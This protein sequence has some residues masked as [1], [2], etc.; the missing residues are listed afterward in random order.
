MRHETQKPCD[1]SC[2]RWRLPVPLASSRVLFPNDPYLKFSGISTTL[3]CEPSFADSSQTV[4]A[5]RG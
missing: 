5:P 2:A 3:M 4:S 1:A